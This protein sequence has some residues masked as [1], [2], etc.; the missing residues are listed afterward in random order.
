M[1]IKGVCFQPA[2]GERVYIKMANQNLFIVFVSPE[3]AISADNSKMLYF[4][5]GT[6]T[7]TYV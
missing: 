6:S 5:R 4:Q 3:N 2:H 1:G 7:A